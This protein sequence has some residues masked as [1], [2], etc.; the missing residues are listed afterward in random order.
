MR[1]LKIYVFSSN[2]SYDIKNFKKHTI[3]YM[4]YPPCFVPF[5]RSAQPIAA[6]KTAAKQSLQIGI[7]FQGMR[8][9]PGEVYGKHQY[10][11]NR[12]RCA[13]EITAS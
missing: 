10:E 7:I 3:R 9:L 11:K 6:S 1:K 12:K 5:S 8:H 4:C 13:N 2:S